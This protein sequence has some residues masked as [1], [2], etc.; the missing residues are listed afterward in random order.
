LRGVDVGQVI[1]HEAPDKKGYFMLRMSM[2]LQTKILETASREL[3]TKFGNLAYVMASLQELRASENTS[4][5]MTIDGEEVTSDGLTALIANSAF[6]GGQANFSFAPKVNPADG[7]LDVL[8]MNDSFVGAMS[9]IGSA[10]KIEGAEF[11][12]HWQGKDITVHEP[13][14]QLITLD[15][16]MFGHTPADI[17]IL[18]NAVQI[19]V[20]INEE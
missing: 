19:V 2:G 20:P 15:G 17:K 11:E 1:C 7:M 9:M 14:Q 13:Q 5:K 12:G 10:L 6:V 4:Y 18:A 8:V 16:E 3:K